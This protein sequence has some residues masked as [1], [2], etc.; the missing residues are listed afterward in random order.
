MSGQQAAK[1]A[2]AEVQ[3][4]PRKRSHFTIE[5]RGV[6]F[7]LPA[8]AEELPGDAVEAGEEGKS[9]IFVREMVGPEKFKEWKQTFAPRRWLMGDLEPLAEK[10]AKPYGFANAGESQASEDS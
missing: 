1:A 10:L 8:T 7:K 4:G 3:K 9:V 5:D 6:T 2:K